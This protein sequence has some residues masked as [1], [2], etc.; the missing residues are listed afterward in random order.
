MD[1]NQ[2]RLIQNIL[3]ADKGIENLSDWEFQFLVSLEQQALKTSRPLT[4][5]QRNVLIDI[6]LEHGHHP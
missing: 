4:Y 6:A 2:E 5:K 1:F 3:A